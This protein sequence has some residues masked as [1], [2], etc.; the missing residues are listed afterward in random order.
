MLKRVKYIARLCMIKIECQLK[1][2]ST[3]SES[4]YEYV[5]SF[6]FRLPLFVAF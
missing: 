4:R 3:D 6:I 2:H 5:F 1:T